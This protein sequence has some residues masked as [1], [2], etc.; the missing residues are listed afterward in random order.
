M[1]WLSSLF[2]KQW[3]NINLGIIL[4]I[5]I[6]LIGGGDFFRGIVSQVVFTGFYYPFSNVRHKYESMMDIALENDQLKE[7]LVETSIKISSFEETVR[8]NE[9]FREVLGF[10]APPEYR[11]LPAKVIS[12]T[13]DIVP[14]LVTI[15]KGSRDSVILNQ[16]VVNQEG[17]IGKITAVSYNFS[18]VQL[19]T[20]PANKVAVRVAKNRD[21][22]I[23]EFNIKDRMI[24][25]NLPIQSEIAI[26][27]TIVTSGLGGIY[28]SG[29]NVALVS[30]VIRPEEEP[31]CGV[32]VEA[33]VNFYSVEEIFILRPRL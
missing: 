14:I 31:F 24:L 1:S 18:T 21:M 11:L 5:S 10:A 12:V 26:G 32:K 28:P 16:V 25:K 30:E 13:S 33:S 27:D 2:P 20:H 17:L 4:I 7:A 6:L 19:L 3:R 8:E 9:R 23:V 29:L 22:G 15:N